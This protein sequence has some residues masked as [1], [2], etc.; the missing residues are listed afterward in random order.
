MVATRHA[1]WAHVPT[2]VPFTPQPAIL[3]PR[4]ENSS[5]GDG[6]REGQA[7]SPVVKSQ[8]TSSEND[9]S[10]EEGHSG[11]D[12]TDDVFVYDCVGVGDS[13]DDLDGTPKKTEEHPQQ[14]L[15]QLRAF[16]T[17]R[18]NRQGSVV[19]TNSGGFSDAPSGGGEGNASLRSSNG[20]GFR[21]FKFDLW[22][23][24][25]YA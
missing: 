25:V 22:W 11:G 9:G 16:N 4:E 15:A 7:P 23:S 10:G 8:P 17:K 13:L 1:T 3:A 18:A 19:K 2:H 24:I 14:D 5:H 20:E 12:S 6:S 21:G